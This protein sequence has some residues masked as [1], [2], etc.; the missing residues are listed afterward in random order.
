MT[1]RPEQQKLMAVRAKQCYESRFSVEMATKR[2][3]RALG[4]DHKPAKQPANTRL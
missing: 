4:I 1:L 2:M 3:L